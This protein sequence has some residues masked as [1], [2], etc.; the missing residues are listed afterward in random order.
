[1]PPIISTNQAQ[2]D[3]TSVLVLQGLRKLE[4]FS[5][6][7][8]WLAHATYILKFYGLESIVDIQVPRPKLKYFL[9]QQWFRRS[10]EVRNWLYFNMSNSVYAQIE[11]RGFNIVLAD[12]FVHVARK[13]CYSC[14]WL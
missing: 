13:V 8:P 3:L 5:D 6:F 1:V 9:A 4:V 7:E 11:G 10:K 14:M 2:G 12:E